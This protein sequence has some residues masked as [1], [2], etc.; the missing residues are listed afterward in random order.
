[1]FSKALNSKKRKLEELTSK[2]EETSKKLKTTKE[3]LVDAK[4]IYNLFIV[5]IYKYRN[6]LH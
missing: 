3:K 5:H 6:I 1:M 2:I 4:V